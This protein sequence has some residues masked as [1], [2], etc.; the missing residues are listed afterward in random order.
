MLSG[1]QSF[2]DRAA[3]GRAKEGW[4]RGR[5]LA[6]PAGIPSHDNF[7]DVFRHLAPGAFQDG[8]TAWLNAA[9]ARLGFDHVQIDDFEPACLPDASGLDFFL[10][11]ISWEKLASGD[12]TGLDV[13]NLDELR[14]VIDGVFERYAA[15][16]IA[17]KT[18]HAYFRTLAWTERSD[19][20][21]SRALAAVLAGGD[22]DESARLALGDW[23]LARAAVLASCCDYV[24]TSGDPLIRVNRRYR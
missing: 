22:I 1:A 16:A 19:D 17:V 20:E 13:G 24:A 3:F 4:L 5:G 23:C 8:F 2:E 12:V 14:A 6:L 7:R 9:C 10:Y 15:C 11:D 18:Q 21:A